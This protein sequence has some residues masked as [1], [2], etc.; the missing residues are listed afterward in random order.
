[1][2]TFE[3]HGICFVP[4]P[5]NQEIFPPTTGHPQAR[6]RASIQWERPCMHRP[7]TPCEDSV[8]LRMWFVDVCAARDTGPGHLEATRRTGAR[9]E[10]RWETRH[11]SP[12]MLVSLPRLLVERL[13]YVLQ[14][15]TASPALALSN[16]LLS[17]SLLVGGARQG[18]GRLDPASPALMVSIPD[19]ARHGLVLA[20][21]SRAY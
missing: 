16:S 7:P 4:H 19:T 18:G 20:T 12:G 1:M 5:K 17:L 8:H 21:S 2:I 14:A 11:E 13:A 9:G 10:T 15:T 6:C 3:Q